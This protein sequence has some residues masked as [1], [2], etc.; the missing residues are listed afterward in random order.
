MKLENVIE[1]LHIAIHTIYQFRV[2][3]FNYYITQ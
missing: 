2:I 1:T 3:L